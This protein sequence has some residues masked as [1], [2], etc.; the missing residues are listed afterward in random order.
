[1]D[2]ICE[3]MRLKPDFIKEYLDIH[4][5]PW[6]GLVEAIKGS[7]FLE[8]YIYLFGNLVIVLMKCEDFEESK[9]R[10]IK[11]EVFKKWTKKVQDMLEEDKKTFPIEGKLTD[12]R[13]VWKLSD[14][15]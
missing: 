6:P 9:K 5:N 1:M 15:N 4:E 7:G 10:L 14:Y 2:V 13:P 3:L 11:H 8:E 12:L